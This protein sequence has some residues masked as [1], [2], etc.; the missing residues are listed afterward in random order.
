VSDAPL[1]D[2]FVLGSLLIVPLTAGETETIHHMPLDKAIILAQ[3]Q[4]TGEA[5]RTIRQHS[6]R[7]AE[8]IREGVKELSG[9]IR[10]LDGVL[11]SQSLER[12]EQLTH[13]YYVIPI[14]IFAAKEQIAAYCAELADDES[15]A[16]G[17]ALKQ[18][19]HDYVAYTY[20]VDTLLPLGWRYQEF[21]FLTI[22]S[23]DLQALRAKTFKVGHVMMSREMN[24]LTMLLSQD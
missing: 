16:R 13:G 1:P 11:R 7:Y 12:C 5:L 14:A 10:E 9:L 18:A 6:D 4:R 3:D 20:P 19:L 24:I 23:Q 2:A 8:G 21:P 22:T 15:E 17:V